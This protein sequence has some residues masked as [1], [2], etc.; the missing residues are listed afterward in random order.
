MALLDA[1]DLRKTY[2]LSKSN[3]VEAL[4]GVDV[5][6]EA[7]EMVAIMGPSGS[8]KSTLM[9]ILGLLHGPDRDGGPPP[10]L[11]IDGRDMT[12]LSDSERTRMRASRMGFVFQSFN[13][14]PTLSADE[15]VALAAD[16]AGVPASRARAA[17]RDAL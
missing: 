3:V 15:N 12:R 10:E 7:G 6:V 2:R 14:V 11:V 1:R 8:G 5:A 17:A 4:R 16:Y 13:L 9:H